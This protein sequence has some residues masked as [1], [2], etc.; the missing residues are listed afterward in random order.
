AAPRRGKRPRTKAFEPDDK[1]GGRIEPAT[2]FFS[3]LRSGEVARRRRR[4]DGGAAWFRALKPDRLHRTRRSCPSTASRS[5]SPLHGEET[6]LQNFRLPLTVSRNRRKSPIK[7]HSG[8][9]NVAGRFFSK[10]KCPTQAKP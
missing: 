5:P 3:S 9:L 7:L 1:K 2:L 10:K 4:R 6:R 8:Y